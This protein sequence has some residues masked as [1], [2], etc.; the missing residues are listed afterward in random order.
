MQGSRPVESNQGNKSWRHWDSEVQSDSESRPFFRKS[1]SFRRRKEKSEEKE[2]SL[3]SRLTSSV[4][5]DLPIP[6]QERR[7]PMIVLTS[8][9]QS[10]PEI[11]CTYCLQ[12]KS[13]RRNTQT[14]KMKS[15]IAQVIFKHNRED[16]MSSLKKCS[17]EDVQPEK[18]SESKKRSKRLPRAHKRSLS[19]GASILRRFNKESSEKDEIARPPLPKRREP[20]VN[21]IY[22]PNGFRGFLEKRKHESAIKQLTEKERVVLSERIEEHFQELKKLFDSGEMREKEKVANSIKELRRKVKHSHVERPQLM[23][24]IEQLRRVEKSFEKVQ[25]QLQIAQDEELLSILLEGTDA[26]RD[27]IASSPG[28]IIKSQ[29]LLELLYQYLEKYTLCESHLLN[30]LHFLRLLTENHN[31]TEFFNEENKGLFHLIIEALEKQPIIVQKDVSNSFAQLLVLLAPSQKQISSKRLKMIPLEAAQEEVDS[32]LKQVIGSPQ[33]NKAL[34]EK[35][36]KSLFHLNAKLYCDLQPCDLVRANNTVHTM[37]RIEKIVRVYNSFSMHIIVKSILGQNEK[38]N[39]AR[40]I[41][42]YL[43]LSRKSLK[44]NDLATVYT[45]YSAFAHSSIG[46]L[47][48]SFQEAF[49]TGS[50]KK[51]YKKMKRLLRITGNSMALRKYIADKRASDIALIPPI[52]LV[53]SDILHTE[54]VQSIAGYG[55]KRCYNYE[56]IN[57]IYRLIQEFL[58]FKQNV[59]EAGKKYFIQPLKH[60][61][62][63]QYLLQDLPPSAQIEDELYDLSKEL[64]S[65]TLD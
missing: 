37:L 50:Y 58:Y 42:F 61:I 52:S 17:L 26:D 47:K 65:T 57:T 21:T 49:Q 24:K 38:V 12:Q 54:E 25:V 39:R 9:E 43:D 23:E 30:C 33:K 10:V 29:T 20:E 1:A 11:K 60:N 59:K 8:T 34:I 16:A 14:K 2:P 7:G 36:A 62:F 35:C 51:K 22:S 45:I 32:F 56:K 19:G 44:L 41:Q 53:M 3:Y 15:L 28:S 5:T 40:L 55:T 31:D 27:V 13:S 64:E 18:N 46:R 6:S 48:A 63:A 4:S